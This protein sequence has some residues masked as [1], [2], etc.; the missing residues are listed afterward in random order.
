MAKEEDKNEC[1]EEG[2]NLSA[3]IKIKIKKLARRRVLGREAVAA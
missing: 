1:K 2:T 3:H